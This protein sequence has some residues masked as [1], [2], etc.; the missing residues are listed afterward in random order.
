MASTA[1]QAVVFD[2]DGVIT[3]TALVHSAAWKE[4]FDQFLRERSGK[5][6][7]E[8]REFSHEKDYL[9][10]VDGKPRYE[11]VKSFLE[12]RGIELPWGDP[13]DD[14]EKETVCGLGNRKNRFF[15]EV[16]Q[17]D[18]V[19]IYD[20]TIELI[21]ELRNSGIRVGVASSSRNCKSVLEKAGIPGL[22]D[23]RVDG[24]VSGELN[25]NGK[26]EPDIFLQSC[27]NMNADPYR[28]VV[29]EDAVSGVQSGRKGNFGFVLGVARDTAPEELL[30]NGADRV[31]RGL[32]ELGG[33]AGIEQWFREGL[34]RDNW[35]LT[36]HGYYPEQEKERESLLTVGNGYFASRGAMEET[37]TNWLF[38]RFGIREGEW[39]TADNCET[40]R[41]QRKLNFNTG[42][43]SREMVIR[44][45]EGRETL[46]E[47]GCF[48]SMHD[49]H[50]A[51]QEYGITPLNYD[52]EIRMIISLDGK[53]IFDVTTAEPGSSGGIL[54]VHAQ[55][56]EPE[57]GM[58]MACKLTVA[59]GWQG[60]DFV[61]EIRADETRV[62]AGIRFRAGK[63]K[64]VVFHKL[65]AMYV[66]GKQDR[67]LQSALNKAKQSTDFE[68]LREQSA[69]AWKAVWEETDIG[70]EGDRRAQKRI[71]MNIYHLLT[72]A[73]RHSIRPGKEIPASGWL[74]LP[75][76]NF[77][78][79]EV[80][81]SALTF[82]HRHQDTF[83]EDDHRMPLTHISVAIAFNVWLYFLVTG[84]KGFLEET[85]AGIFLEIC[86]FWSA[87]SVYNPDTGTYEITG[88]SKPDA[89][90]TVL[91][92]LKKAEDIFSLVE[93]TDIDQRERARWTDIIQKTEPE[94][95]D[96]EMMGRLVKGTILEVY[97]TDA[98]ISIHRGELEISPELPVQREKLNFSFY[99]R[100]H[101]YILE[102]A[103][104]MVR[105]MIRSKD[106]NPV[107]VRIRGK[108]HF[109]QPG[110]WT[111]CIIKSTQN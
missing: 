101:R 33:M 21:H 49:P 47:S 92:L 34:A 67:P 61:P 44:D 17:R 29:V 106:K 60:K 70:L 7:E 87:R 27:E 37:A 66:S 77:H 88:T 105:L 84:D 16:L 100:E 48:V 81:R 3:Q 19:R 89:I 2:L 43:L 78:L 12:S 56:R 83:L 23:T 75:F 38:F 15:N 59:S 79:P 54:H 72:R 10:Y 35:N 24:I 91:W 18:G 39:L 53:L 26:P 30:A 8:F 57:T 55:D 1:F 80:N 51:G 76:L 28:S 45:P 31:V 99:F 46:I 14:P 73:S 109:I 9:P 68:L 65:L 22:F 36:V 74:M 64:K 13:E 111:N 85:G 42:W 102:I 50:L 5:T 11:G 4:M 97:F 96:E 69:G 98:G 104:S 94:I 25:L 107:P 6:G 32:A 40:I 93:K 86:R 41:L 110:E 71:R 82:L 58:A 103:R 90:N 95:P 20:S 63:G 62:H 52:D 108:K